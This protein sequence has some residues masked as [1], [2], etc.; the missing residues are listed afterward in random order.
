MFEGDML[1]PNLEFNPNFEGKSD[2]GDMDDI[3]K[4]VALHP[5]DDESVSDSDSDSDD[6]SPS[7]MILD[8]AS[9][10]LQQ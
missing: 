3:N 5:R 10:V 6:F 4:E 9:M 7:E 2:K 8:S 1:L